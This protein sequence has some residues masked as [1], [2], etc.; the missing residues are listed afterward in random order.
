M[1]E[2]NVFFLIIINKNK[3]PSRSSLNIR[4]T[5]SSLTHIKNPLIWKP[6]E[7]LLLKAKKAT[8]TYNDEHAS[9]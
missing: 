2:K 9:K 6:S 7:E 5:L 4:G 8:K 3:T 1:L